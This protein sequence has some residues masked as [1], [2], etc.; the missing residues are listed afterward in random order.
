MQT[1]RFMSTICLYVAGE[2]QLL[3]VVPKALAEV[4]IALHLY[5]TELFYQR[6]PNCADV[7]LRNY[8]LTHSFTATRTL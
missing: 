1:L 2:S 6:K 5:L 8:S 4:K 3:H 7:P